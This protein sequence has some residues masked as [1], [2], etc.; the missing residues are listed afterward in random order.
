M[1]YRHT[2]TALALAAL[3][4]AGSGAAADERKPAGPETRAAVGKVT[5]GTLLARE[6][7]GKDWKALGKGDTV[8][9]RDLVLAPPGARATIKADGGG[10]ELTLWG[11]LPVLSEF[12]VLESAVVLHAGA[13][14]DLDFTLERGRVVVTSTGKKAATVHVR[15]ADQSWTF[16]LE[17][18]GTSV[19]LER[20]GR[21]MQGVPFSKDTTKP[22]VPDQEVVCTLLKGEARLN[23]GERRLALQAPPGQAGYHWDNNEGA[24]QAVSR[25][26]KAPSW[27]DEKTIPEDVTRTIEGLVNDFSR[28]LKEG[29][30]AGNALLILRQRAA[31]S[32]NER[33]RNLGRSIAVYGFAAVGD[34]KNL[35]GAL[36]DDKDRA[37]RRTAILAL[38]HFVGQAPGKDQE[39]YTFLVKEKKYPRGKAETVASLL[40]SFGATDLKQP[41]TYEVLIGYL[42]DAKLAVRELAHWH[43]LRH[44]PGGNKLKYD[45]AGN[46]DAR[47]KG[48][49]EWTELVP[50][51]TLPKAPKKP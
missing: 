37:V 5:S 9:S 23:T 28:T 47:E 31:K 50:A 7:P 43:L 35:L 13:K 34:V 19:A 22:A 44:V 45:A 6:G 39:V 11:N 46:A 51:G 8:H 10:A 40:H 4:L 21:M 38:R 27:A 29:N 2:L 30:S 1:R 18:Q 36:E 12:P 41:E 26:E 32:R 3:A 42:H 48:Y 16:T 24:D 15:F 17:K 33:E 14:G 20:V 49:K 25:I